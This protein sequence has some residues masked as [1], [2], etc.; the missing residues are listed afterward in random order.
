V[1]AGVLLAWF[2]VRNPVYWAKNLAV[3]FIAMA[4]LADA[5]RHRVTHLHANFGSS[6]ATIAWLGKKALG[7][8]MSVTFHA[9]I[10]SLPSTRMDVNT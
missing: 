6:P 9:L 3:F 2:S 4:V 8:G 5:R 7:T 1:K 10:S